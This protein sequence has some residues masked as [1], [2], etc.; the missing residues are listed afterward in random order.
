MDTISRDNTTNWLPVVG[1]IA[2]VLAIGLSIG[3][4]YSAS[5]ARNDLEVV[6][7]ALEDKL[8]TIESTA[9]T[10]NNTANQVTRDLKA[11][12]DGVAKNEQAL[13]DNFETLKKEVQDSKTKAVKPGP[14]G[15]SDTPVAKGEYKVKSGDIGTSIAK[16]NGVSLQAL[17]D[18]NPGVDWKRLKVGQI[19]KIPGSSAPAPAPHN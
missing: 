8:G 16:D 14:K 10:A 2:I 11:T 18:A 6:K 17:L 4:M 19:I 15:S 3:A 13:N 7:T 9:N 5:H 12:I 1:G